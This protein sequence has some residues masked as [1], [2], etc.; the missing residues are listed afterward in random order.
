MLEGHTKQKQRG[1]IVT[2]L[3]HALAK[4]VPTAAG[5]LTL[6]EMYLKDGQAA[7]ALKA[8]RS[9]LKYVNE[10]QQKYHQEPMVQVRTTASSEIST[11]S[12]SQFSHP[13]DHVF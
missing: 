4:G 9:G 7:A 2:T 12:I 10:R 5:W 13:E 3:E 11:V 6:A 8:A 1:R